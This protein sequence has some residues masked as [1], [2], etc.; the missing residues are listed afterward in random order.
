MSG[1][2]GGS[3]NFKL[4]EKGGTV[5]RWVL[6]SMPVIDQICEGRHKCEFDSDVPICLQ[7]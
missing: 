3:Q 7:L 5:K 6:F 2:A 4:C 1:F